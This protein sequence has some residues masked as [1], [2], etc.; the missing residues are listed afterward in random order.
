MRVHRYG[1][2]TDWIV[3]LASD[4]DVHLAT[5]LIPQRDGVGCIG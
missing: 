2:S 3:L 1:L 5:H 4:I